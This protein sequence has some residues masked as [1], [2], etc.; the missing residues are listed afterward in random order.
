MNKEAYDAVTKAWALTIKARALCP[1]I[2]ESAIGRTGYISPEWYRE[3]GAV[4]F[5]NLA[6]S[7]TAGDVQELNQIGSFM[8][9]SFVISMAA[10][11][12]EYKVVP[13]KSKPDSSK[14]GSKHVQL[15]KRL[16]NRFAHG[17]WEYNADCNKH[18]ET[19]ELLEELFPE[20]SA[21]G[22]GFVTS[23]D[24]I[25]EPLKDGVLAYIRAAT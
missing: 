11:L 21:K 14:E 7:L 23:I 19:R 15:T 8:N 6:Q 10:V 5:V 22:S 4:Y 20:G 12:E 1:F 17:Q 25:L 16:R 18:V 2:D 3:R 24:D 13:Y 9:R